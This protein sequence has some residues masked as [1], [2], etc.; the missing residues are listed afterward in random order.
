MQQKE[1]LVRQIKKVKSFIDELEDFEL[2]TSEAVELDLLKED[3]N[4]AFKQY[5]NL[6]ATKE[7]GEASYRLFDITDCEFNE[8]HLRISSQIH[9]IKRKALE[10]K[11]SVVSSHSGGSCGKKSSTL[12]SSSTHSRKIKAA[13]KATRLEAEMKYLGKDAKL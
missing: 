1:R 10:E 5:H 13:E 11:S 9:A 3:V 12:S 7:E 4:Q 6:T 2:L 8:C